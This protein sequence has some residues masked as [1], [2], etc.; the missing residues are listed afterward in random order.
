MEDHLKQNLMVKRKV[1]CVGFNKTGTTSLMRAFENLGYNVG[2]QRTAERML[3]DYENGNFAPILEY[4]EGADA[5]QDVPFSL[6]NTYRHLY[7]RFPESLFILSVRSSAE[8]WYQSL[9]RFHSKLFNNGE[10]PTVEVLR[11]ALY[12]EKGWIWRFNQCLIKSSESNP[13]EKEN[14][15]NCYEQH[16][17]DVKDFFKDRQ[18]Q[19]L[20]LDVSASDAYSRLCNF[21]GMPQVEGDFPW[22]NSTDRK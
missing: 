3:G 1:F 16:N 20:V 4:C 9:S 22:E 17:R 19:L 13:Y 2:D 12:V 8:Q 5:F 10:I 7:A 14:A 18:N 11:N 6:P 21:L 15:I